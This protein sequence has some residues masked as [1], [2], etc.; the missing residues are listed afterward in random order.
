MLVAIIFDYFES[1]LSE[2][3]C[4]FGA[5]NMACSNAEMPI[6]CVKKAY[7]AEKLVFELCLRPRR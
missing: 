6:S 5:V 4:Q 1:I 7:A 2:R 3:F